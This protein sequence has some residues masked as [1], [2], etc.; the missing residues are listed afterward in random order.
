MEEEKGSELLTEGRMSRHLKVEI[1]IN[2][3]LIAVFFFSSWLL[4]IWA[5]SSLSDVLGGL[6]II[7][8]ALA[9]LIFFRLGRIVMAIMIL[10]VNPIRILIRYRKEIKALLPK[11]KKHL[12]RLL[13]IIP[14]IPGLLIVFEDQI[15]DLAYD[16]RNEIGVREKD[17][18]KTSSDFYRELADRGLLFTGEDEAVL[19]GLNAR[20]KGYSNLTYSYY[21]PATMYAVFRDDF[22]DRKPDD[23]EGSDMKL[24]QQGEDI[25][26]PFYVYN[27]IVTR[28]EEYDFLHYEPVAWY[29]YNND[30]PAGGPFFE[31]IFI[32]CKILYIN[33]HVYAIIGVDESYRVGKTWAQDTSSELASHPYY[34]LLSE[35]EDVT[36]Y[37]DGSYYSEGAINTLDLEMRRNTNDK[38]L[39]LFENYP[40]R[41]FEKLDFNA[42]DIAISE[43]EYDYLKSRLN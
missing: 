20:Y 18:G 30:T 28:T 1:I 7:G 10:I 31:D 23:L 19:E 4:Q 33:G 16:I 12:A 36:T 2:F 27:A 11:R 9:I 14:M 13:I 26:A 40:V 8:S 42:I 37:V 32:E 17:Q 3:A 41:Y 38:D 39:Y 5:L 22:Y 15:S 24:V 29:S 21:T 35:S 25:K 6:D 43:L 34:I